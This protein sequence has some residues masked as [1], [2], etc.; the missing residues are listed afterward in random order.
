MLEVLVIKKL[1]IILKKI[2]Y[3]A[4]LGSSNYVRCKSF[5]DTNIKPIFEKTPERLLYDVIINL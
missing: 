5:N 1:L 2:E 4:L 3:Y